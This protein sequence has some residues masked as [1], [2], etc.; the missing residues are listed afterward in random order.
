[1]HSIKRNEMST[2]VTVVGEDEMIKDEVLFTSTQNPKFF[3]DSL[4]HQIFRCMYGVL[5]INE[6]KN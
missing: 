3:Q 4:S 2:L 1:M 6:N 5:D